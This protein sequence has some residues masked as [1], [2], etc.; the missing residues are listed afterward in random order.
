VHI[1]QVQG[2]GHFLEL[3]VVLGENEPAET[4]VLEANDLMG[5]LGVQQHQLLEQAYVDLLAQKGV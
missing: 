4:G 2:L 5:R 1:D 3:E